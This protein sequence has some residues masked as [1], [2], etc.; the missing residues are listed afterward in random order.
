MLTLNWE[1]D[2][3]LVSMLHHFPC[4]KDAK[5]IKLLDFQ[6]GAMVLHLLWPHLDHPG[7]L[8]DSTAKKSSSL[9]LA[10]QTAGQSFNT[11]NW[12]HGGFSLEAN[13]DN[14]HRKRVL[15]TLLFAQ[16]GNVSGHAPAAAAK[17]SH[18]FF[19]H[20]CLPQ[21]RRQRAACQNPSLK[22]FLLCLLLF[23]CIPVGYFPWNSDTAYLHS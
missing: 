9:W 7:T 6:V 23:F 12:G 15:I 1:A 16:C 13:V 8:T 21:C 10:Q 2:V 5:N 4:I 11:Y 14:R 18:T 22:W 17:E 20:D 3:L 19:Y